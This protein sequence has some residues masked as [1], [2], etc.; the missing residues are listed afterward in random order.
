MA[1]RKII[2]FDDGFLRKK[3]K[4]ITKF[5]DKLR[6]LLQ[7]MKDTLKNAEG[8]GLAA[9]QVGILRRIFIIDTGEEIREFINPRLVYLSKE[10][11]CSGEGCLSFPE[12]S[13]VIERPA[14]AIVRAF[15]IEG[16]EFE[17]EGGELMARALC[18]ETDHLNGILYYDHPEA[19][20]EPEDTQKEEV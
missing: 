1:F 16:N 11:Q 9:V 2:T 14:K 6:Q 8:V 10:T 3:S 13:K 15:D 20:P 17:Y 7:D 18:H 4:E 12:K 19:Q 5:D